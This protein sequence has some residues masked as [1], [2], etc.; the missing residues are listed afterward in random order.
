[1]ELVHVVNLLLCLAIVVLGVMGYRKS[2]HRLPLSL[3][4]VFGLFA[5]S[6]GLVLSGL[7]PDMGV[8]I[9]SLRVAAYSLVILLL[10]KYIQVLDVF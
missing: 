7:L 4:A 6:H 9:I 1:M 2:R 3:A 10:Y 8:I 5:L